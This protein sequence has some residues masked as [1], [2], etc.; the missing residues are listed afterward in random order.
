MNIIEKNID[1]LSL[2]EHNPRQNDNA[3]DYVANSIKA[4]GFKVPCLISGTGEVICGH[5]RIKAAIKLGMTAVP[6]IIADDLTEEQIRA[7]RLVDNQTA[8]IADWDM[9]MLEEELNKLADF[10]MDDFGF[11]LLFGDDE[12]VSEKPQ[13]L[14]QGGEIDTDEYADDKFE[15]TCPKCGFKFNPKE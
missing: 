10:D 8:A 7:F 11:D 12:D 1:E 5:T 4:F 13:K 2:Y 9:D 15:C 6:C 14:N 3:V